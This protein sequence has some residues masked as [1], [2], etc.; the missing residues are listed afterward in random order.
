MGNLEEA[1]KHFDSA[2]NLCQRGCFA[3]AI[4]EFTEAIRLAP[5]SPEPYC[6]RGITYVQI[7]NYSGAHAD[8]EKALKLDPSNA[9][10]KENISLAKQAEREAA[11]KRAAAERSAKEADE[12]AA[13][14]R[15]AME[16][17]ERLRVAGEQGDTEAQFQLGIAYE[18]GNGV[19]RDYVKSREFIRKAAKQGHKEAKDFLAREKARKAAKTFDKIKVKLILAIICGV[20]GGLIGL[21]PNSAGFIGV[22][23][24]FCLIGGVIIARGRF[25]WGCLGSVISAI[26]GI[27]IGFICTIPS[28]GAGG[29]DYKADVI[30]QI[31][32]GSILGFLIGIFVI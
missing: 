16:R 27:V 7:G 28:L 26:L 32:N 24:L 12:R 3:S 15:A 20:I 14:W 17:I 23:T 13:A 29:L 10:Y 2:M 5:D 25:Y 30:V 6:N 11:D 4:P 31:I 18:N 1:Q 21:I 8:F 22:M 9:K 19:S